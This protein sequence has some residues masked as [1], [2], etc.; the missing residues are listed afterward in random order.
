MRPTD[1]IQISQVED[2]PTAAF[3]A[4]D[5]SFD[6]S[7]AIAFPYDDPRQLHPVPSRRK[8]Y[9]G[10]PADW[11]GATSGWKALFIARSNDH[12]VGYAMMSE[13]WNGMADLAEIAVDRRARGRGVAAAL[14][15]RVEVCADDKGFGLIRLETQSN[16][17][18]AC[19]VY[20][21]AGYTLGGFDHKL[22]ADG[23]HEGEVAL[24]WYKDLR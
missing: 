5:F 22:Y 19:R 2:F 16:N 18:A 21:R 15:A 6:I 17:P 12:V 23:P 13:Y 24:F 10:D 1:P 8:D 4:C 7:H 20:A 14:L 3:A 11:D 9:G